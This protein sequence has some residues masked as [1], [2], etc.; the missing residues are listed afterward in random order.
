MQ[1]QV[2]WPIGI[3]YL[4]ILPEYLFESLDKSRDFGISSF[5]NVYF[6]T[7]NYYKVRNLVRNIEFRL[8]YATLCR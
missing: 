2:S 1:E 6:Y 7:Q 4:T 3:Y 8:W 5:S